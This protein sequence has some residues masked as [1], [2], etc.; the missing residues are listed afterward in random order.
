MNRVI[1]L[2]VLLFLVLL[3]GGLFYLVV[4]R[5]FVP[6]FLAALFAML[7]QPLHNWVLAKCRGYNRLGSTLTTLAILLIVLIPTVIVVYQGA[8][9]AVRL[10]RNT[11]RVHFET[12]SF[13]RLVEQVNSWF[14]LQ[15][16]P[17]E[18]RTEMGTKINEWLAPIA[19]KTPTV[20]LDFLIGCFVFILALYYFLADGQQMLNTVTKLVPLEQR[21]QQRL[22]DEFEE[23]SRAV[24][25]AHLLGGLAIAI[26]A[27]LG[28]AIVGAKSVFLLMMLTF[29]GSMVPIVG[30]AS[31]WVTVCAWLAFVD[32][33]IPA[34]IVLG[35]YCLVVVTVVD[36]ILKPMLL[37]GQSKLNPLLAVL[38]VL[39]G[40]EAL[41]P[42]GV[43]VGPMAVAF[44]QVGLN[45][46]QTQL[47][48]LNEPKHE[49][50]E[51]HRR[52]K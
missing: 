26:L 40:V 29:L 41:G 22:I 6:L 36:S 32:D 10:M 5:F 3:F 50:S 9:D 33:R 7:F 38:S 14:S 51:S 43:F 17:K 44:L 16:D 35:V 15:L 47:A 2:I 23:I 20:L 1:S 8:H 39:G 52:Q 45:M 18:I 37:H 31:I 11:D 48:D 30:S 49:A 21:H 19:T 13:D 42:I 25:G 4:F 28:F 12:Q 34:A 46:L 27:G 24:V